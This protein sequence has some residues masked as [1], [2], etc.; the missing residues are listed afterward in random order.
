MSDF[1]VYKLHALEKIDLDDI[2]T[3]VEPLMKDYLWHFNPFHLV[4]S[5][6]YCF[7]GKTIFEDAI[8]DE[9]KIVDLIYKISNEFP[10]IAE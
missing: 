4:Q 7:Q 8:A 9:W 6:P 1:V 5:D 2:L 10:V 3:F